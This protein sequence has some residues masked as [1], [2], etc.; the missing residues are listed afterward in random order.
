MAGQY[1]PVKWSEYHLLTQKLA[2][3]ILSCGHKYDE[4]VAISRGGLTL[5]H[6]L[7]DL[8]HL[9][10]CTFAIQSY[11]D[12]KT[13]GEVIITQ[14]LSKPINDK[15]V[16]LVDDVADSGITLKRAV[17]YIEQFKPAKITIVTM[18]FK[19]R[20]TFRP[21]FFAEQ[22]TKWILFPY[23]PTEMIKLISHKMKE[24]GKNK[25]QIQ[26]YLEKLGYSDSQIAFTRK[27]Y[28]K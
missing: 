7:S 13:Q 26:T 10:I 16:L 19:P 23:E 27:Y 9:S 14:P 24:E 3:T 11:T 15:N 28:L 1:L 8:L 12:I 25:A 17:S 20:S 21:D 22:T 6:L 2:A 18:F 4:I 5:G